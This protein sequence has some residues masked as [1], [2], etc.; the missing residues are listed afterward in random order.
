MNQPIVGGG[1][2]SDEWQQA[3][4]KYQIEGFDPENLEILPRDEFIQSLCGEIAQRPIEEVVAAQQNIR[5]EEKKELREMAQQYIVLRDRG[6]RLPKF[7]RWIG[8]MF[9]NNPE[10][11]KLV[12]KI[13]QDAGKKGV[14]VS[15]RPVD[16]LRAA[17]TEHFWSCL[18]D[19][20]QYMDVLPAVLTET[21][22]IGVAYID[23]DDG[24]MQGRTWVHHAQKDGK[25]VVVLASQYGN[26][27]DFTALAD[28]FI[29]LGYDT[30][31]DV[32]WD[33][34][35][36]ANHRVEYVNCFT[37]SLHWDTYTW[38]RGEVRYVPPSK[39]VELKKAA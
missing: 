34:D 31:K 13:G 27:V 14:V 3:F 1:L 4:K 29:N 22:G 32:R 19:G 10:Y 18:N 24:K 30:Y 35:G 16:I 17:D 5:M 15:C 21:S 33:Y 28:Y 20:G 37:R 26:G 2:S 36:N 38:E 7:G 9:S 6:A 39:I 8:S 23:G 12:S 25:D 11:L